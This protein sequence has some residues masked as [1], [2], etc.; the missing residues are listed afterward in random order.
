MSRCSL[1]SKSLAGA[2]AVALALGAL[3]VPSAGATT[4]REVSVNPYCQAM[5]ASHPTPP[6]SGAATIYR[7]WAREHLGYFEKL[8]KEATMAQAKNSLRVLV[9]I[10]RYEARS[11]NMKTLD[12]YVQ[13]KA[14]T[15]LL[16][17]QIFDVT[18]VACAKWAVN[19]L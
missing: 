12:A 10:L 9:P 1:R 14:L 7:R 15:W 17:W 19:L 5:I 3:L 6:T 2:V 8:Q 18:V 16:Q 13:S 11:T 4:G